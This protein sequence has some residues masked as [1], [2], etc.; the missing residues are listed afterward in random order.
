MKR[1]LKFV[2]ISVFVFSIIVLSFTNRLN[3][4][5]LNSEDIITP[6]PVSI[7]LTSKLYFVYGDKLRSE[8]RVIEFTNEQF[9]TGIAEEL[10]KGP[11]NRMYETPFIQQVQILSV[12]L[13]DNIVY[14]NLNQDFMENEYWSG[15][16]RELFIWSIV[17]TFTEIEDAYSVQILVEGKKPNVELGGF[18]MM[19]PLPRI[20]DFIYV[21]KQHP[22]DVVINF[23]DS[24]YLKRFDIAYDYIDSKSRA[25][26][27]YKEFVELM[28]EY[29]DRFYG[30]QR[31]IYFTQD[32]K[33]SKVVHVKY[34][35]NNDL[36]MDDGMTPDGMPIQAEVFDYWE[37]IE[38]D[39]VW[40][41]NF[42]NY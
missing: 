10:V 8:D 42:R 21:K 31:G 11:K 33:D 2:F 16:R 14:V 36:F 29:Y 35:R 9:E 25:L 27:R 6:N 19:E 30:Y 26:L 15:D 32:F 38:E 13:M 28:E 37:L 12:E 22:S 4:N 41:I 1:T 18:N 40:K 5:I 34:I 20:E 39:G 24:I 7:K 17:N 23:L 3:S